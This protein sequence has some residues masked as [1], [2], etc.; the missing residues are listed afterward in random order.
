MT[1]YYGLDNTIDFGT[2][3]RGK[4]LREVIEQHKDDVVWWVDNLRWFH[5]AADAQEVMFGSHS[6]SEFKH[7]HYSGIQHRYS[8]GRRGR[9]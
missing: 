6:H 7:D 2:K 8:S 5:L 3:H 4:K 9:R 1:K